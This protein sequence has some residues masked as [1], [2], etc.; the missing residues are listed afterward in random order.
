[1]HTFGPAT[2]NRRLHLQLGDEI[3]RV[4][5]CMWGSFP[6]ANEENIYSVSFIKPN[7]DSA[8]LSVCVCVCVCVFVFVCV[9][10]CVCV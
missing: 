7:N 8:C 1:M 9:C 6:G 4:S 3:P 2:E 10:V 5:V